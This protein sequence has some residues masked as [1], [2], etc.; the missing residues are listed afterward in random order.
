MSIVSEITR[1]QNAKSAIKTAIENKG[2]TVGNGTLDTYADKI[3]DIQT[4]GGSSV[5]VR[6]DVNF[7]DYDGTLLHSYTL[8]EIQALTELPE[9]PTQQGLICQGWN[10][11][12]ADLKTENKKTNVG[13]IY[14][15][16][17]GKTRL[18]IHIA[19]DEMLNI[20]LRFTQ[21]V[22]NGVE[23]DWGDGSSIEMFS[24]NGNTAILP[25]H[26]YSNVGDYVIKLNPIDNCTLFLGGGS[27]SYNIMNSANEKNAP[28]SNS[29]LKVEIGKNVSR[30]SYSFYNCRGLLNLTIPNSVTDLGYQAFYTCR[31]LR[32][33]IIPNG[34]TTINSYMFNGC[35][36]L[37][38]IIIP[39]GITKLNDNTFSNCYKLSNITI[40][41]SVT[42]IGNNVFSYCYFLS[43]III[44]S[45]V[46]S[47]GS[48][49]FSDCFLLSNLEIPNNITSISYG[50][51]SNCYILP[52]VTIPN[53]VTSI[54]T[55]AF[56]ECQTLSKLIMPSG[57]ESIASNAFYNCY[58]LT[59]YD[60]SNCN[61]IPSLSN[62][63][64]FTGINS[65]CKI[66]VPDNLYNDW[67]ATSG[68][69]TY[70]SYIIKASEA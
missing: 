17:D 47:I 36:N 59:K 1:L 64:A 55:F 2:V 51:F 19:T 16:D 53:G 43:D 70:A 11:T 38:S 37:S 67:I 62:A 15:T 69:S 34:I 35:Y 27:N 23:V 6:K 52:N 40:P 29:L 61:S 22:S 5:V 14:I 3:N 60:F 28:Y 18:Y 21:T 63:N 58:G 8:A 46:T 32:N 49:P 31:L 30:I 33:I 24:G 50:M 13:A 26:T 48:G 68:W 10:W 54:S 45:S 39:K 44:P 42:T 57:L 20:S 25:T 9:L 7:Y 4:G 65:N 12:L 66:I 41:T 56:R